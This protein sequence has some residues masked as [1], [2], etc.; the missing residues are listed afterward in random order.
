MQY[1]QYDDTATRLSQPRSE[2]Q[3]ATKQFN[4]AMLRLLQRFIENLNYGNEFSAYFYLHGRIG[5][6]CLAAF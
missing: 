4:R 5:A 3:C 1:F 6:F 2:S